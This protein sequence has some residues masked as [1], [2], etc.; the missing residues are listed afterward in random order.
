MKVVVR[1]EEAQELPEGEAAKDTL[2]E[3]EA[4]REIVLLSEKL[5]EALRHTVAVRHNEGEGEPLAVRVAG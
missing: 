4:L 5:G 3:D 2:V 1:V